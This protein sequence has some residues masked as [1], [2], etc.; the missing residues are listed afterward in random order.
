MIVSLF[1]DANN[2]AIHAKRVTL[3]EK[4][5]TLAKRIRNINTTVSVGAPTLEE[6]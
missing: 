6:C 1:E 5:M 2:C 4:D 3:M